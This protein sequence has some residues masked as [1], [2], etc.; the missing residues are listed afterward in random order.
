MQT[1]TDAEVHLDMVR[2][3]TRSQESDASDVLEV[4]L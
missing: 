4:S 3:L 1:I 2:I